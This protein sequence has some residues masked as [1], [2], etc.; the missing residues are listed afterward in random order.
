MA[1]AGR[2]HPDEHL[3]RGQ[4]GQLDLGLDQRLAKP[5]KYGCAYHCH[6]CPFGAEVSTPP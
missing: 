4:A 6:P 2:H 1:D 3:V 5:L